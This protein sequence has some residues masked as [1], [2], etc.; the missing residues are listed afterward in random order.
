MRVQCA[1][2]VA[3]FFAASFT[4]NT[5]NTYTHTHTHTHTHTPAMVVELIVLLESSPDWSVPMS[6]PDGRCCSTA[7]GPEPRSIQLRNV[8]WL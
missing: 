6:L 1:F 8:Y 4:H 3:L 2:E 7:L 5:Y